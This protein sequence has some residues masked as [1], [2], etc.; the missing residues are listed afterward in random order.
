MSG[1]IYLLARFLTRWDVENAIIW[2]SNRNNKKNTIIAE[3][4]STFA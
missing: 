2:H 4:S 3:R 1:Q